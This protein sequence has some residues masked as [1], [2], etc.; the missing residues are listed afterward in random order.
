MDKIEIK[1]K[2]ISL[3]KTLDVYTPN[4][5]HTQHVVRCPYCG[6][7][8]NPTS[9]HFSIKID[10]DS[11]DAMIYRCFKCPE[12]G[13]L[14]MDTLGDL[15]LY[16]DEEVSISLKSFNRKIVKKN[17]YLSNNIKSYVIPTVS[18]TDLNIQK[19]SYFN[20]RMG[21]EYNLAEAQGLKIIINFKDF[22]K[23]N[24]IKSIP[25]VSDKY[26]NFISYNYIGFLGT[27]N[28]T[29][30]F[31]CIRD[32]KSMKKHIKVKL[33]PYSIHPASFY[34]IPNRIDLMYTNDIHI[35]IAEGVF[36]I[37]SIYTNLLNRDTSNN[38]FYGANGFSYLSILRYIIFT[39]INT[40]IHL[41]I[42][43][44]SDKTD[45]NHKYYLFKK[46]PLYVWCDAIYI[47]R[48]G[49]IG[50]KDYGVPKERIIDT[51]KKI[52]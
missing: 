5:L 30:S 2:I 32:D 11:D 35:H 17:K 1:Y 28:N 19:L 24:E 20:S 18:D 27:D 39:G 37:A 15:G 12:A 52:K 49:S 14:T 22:L 43:S 16:A 47:H 31:R 40:G 10:V 9:G 3:L 13:L 8:K 48:N 23:V 38:L 51:F 7:S 6:D 42:Y 45:E 50:E 34:N 41:H 25:L 4:S 29:I 44:D 33:D 26:I 21:F 46:S 36:D